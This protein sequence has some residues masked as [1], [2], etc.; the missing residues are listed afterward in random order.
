[1]SLYQFL[2]AVRLQDGQQMQSDDG[3]TTSHLLGIFYRTIRM[4]EN[5]L[6]PAYVF[7]GKPPEMKGGELHKRLERREKATTEAERIRET[8]TAEEIAKLERRTVRVSK[9]QNEEAQTLLELMGIPFIVAPSEAEAQCA[10]LAKNGKVYAAGSEDMDTLTFAAPILLRHLTA[11]EA[12]KQPVGEIDLNK[13]LTLLELTHDQ[14]IDL[15]I[16]LGCDYCEPIPGVGPVT[17]YKLIQEHKTLENIINH[18]KEKEG[19][20]KV[21]ENWPY[22]VVQDLFKNPEVT[23]A[24]EVDLKWNPPNVDGLVDYLVKEKGFSEERVRAGAAK[25][26]KGFNAKPQGRIMDFFK[27]TTQ[28]PE[29]LQEAAKRKKQANDAEKAKKKAKSSS[30]KR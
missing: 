4:V 12:K 1:M 27:P 5:G 10:E 3:E 14:F 23:P 7:D 30:K 9:E 18:L 29:K 17:A 21:P 20:I 22:E 11:S 8:G 15:C 2:I 19:K 26:T 25:L 24:A 16:L 6:K 28:S 13:C